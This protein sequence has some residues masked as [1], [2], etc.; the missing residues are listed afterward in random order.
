M[1]DFVAKYILVHNNIK[2]L[3]HEFSLPVLSEFDLMEIPNLKIILIFA[4]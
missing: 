3:L 4:D 1:H 2:L